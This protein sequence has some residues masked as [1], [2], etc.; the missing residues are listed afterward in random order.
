MISSGQRYHVFLC[1]KGFVVVCKKGI[2]FVVVVCFVL[3]FGCLCAMRQPNCVSTRPPITKVYFG[4]CGVLVNEDEKKTES[5][6]MTFSRQEWSNLHQSIKESVSS[7]LHSF[8]SGRLSWIMSRFSII[9][10]ALLNS[11]IAM[12]VR[13]RVV[14]FVEQHPDLY[15]E[16]RYLACEGALC[17][18]L[19]EDGVIDRELSA[20]FDSNQDIRAALQIIANTVGICRENVKDFIIK[21][22][23]THGINLLARKRLWLPI[24]AEMLQ[25]ISVLNAT[26]FLLARELK[27]KGFE[28]FLVTDVD[29]SVIDAYACKAIVKDAIE[30]FGQA[31]IIRL[32]DLRR[33]APPG[34]CVVIDVNPTTLLAASRIGMFSV[35]FRAPYEQVLDRLYALGVFKLFDIDTIKERVNFEVLRIRCCSWW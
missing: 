24:R 1:K 12:L 16:Q 6:L 8:E 4:L 11:T 15:R 18:M 27:E 13:E 7:N 33:V 35:D 31:H 2:W 28:V 3:F 25:Y 26:G 10:C 23:K 5:L 20:I 9:T 30:I 22:I 32:S 29:Q 19:Y 21:K 14:L 34:E 17:N